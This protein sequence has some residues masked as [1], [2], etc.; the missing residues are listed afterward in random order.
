MFQ[1]LYIHVP[2]CSNKC[3]YCCFYSIVSKQQLLRNQYIKKLKKEIFAAKPSCLP[4]TS[5][6]VGGGTPTELSVNDL[7]TILIFI[8]E[9]LP[10]AKDIEFTFE[11]NP[12]GTTEEK[13]ALFKKYGVNRLSFGVQSMTGFNKVLHRESKPQDIHDAVQ[14]ALQTGF[15]NI[16]IDLIYGIPGQSPEHWQKELHLAAQMPIRHI[17]AYSLT[18]EKGSSFS[19]FIHTEA[20]EN[21]QVEM[22]HLA[23]KILAEY[24]INRYEISNYARPGFECRHNLDI[25]L[26]KTYLGCGPAASSFDGRN[27]WTNKADLDQWLAGKKVDS[28]LL[29]PQKRAAEITAFGFRTVRGWKTEEL[30]SLPGNIDAFEILSDKISCLI[31]DGLL[32]Q[33][34]NFIKPTTDGLLFADTV[35]LEL[36]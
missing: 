30:R 36:L 19:K 14:K 8:K 20:D 22:W 15:D 6:Y 1:A 29:S 13:L 5:I 31:K 2:F 35:A 16:S 11:C 12:A 25:W 17:S 10:L 32:Q 27:R 26:G 4:L 3:G 24:D 21:L 7:E 33:K 28:D 18:V 9:N 34:D 23:D